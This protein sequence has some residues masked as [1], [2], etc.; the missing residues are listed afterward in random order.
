MISRLLDYDQKQTKR[1]RSIL[2]NQTNRV[3]TGSDHGHGK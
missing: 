2:N 3:K 1:P